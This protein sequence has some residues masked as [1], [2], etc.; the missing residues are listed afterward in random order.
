MRG[1]CS[2]A[3]GQGKRA[4]EEVGVSESD[5]SGVVNIS[6]LTRKVMLLSRSRTTMSAVPVSATPQDGTASA[7]AAY[8]IPSKKAFLQPSSRT[9]RRDPASTT[10]VDLMTQRSKK[11]TAATATAPASR[12][13]TSGLRVRGDSFKSSRDVARGASG[14]SG[15]STAARALMVH[16]GAAGAGPRPAERKAPMLCGGGSAV[17][18]AAPERVCHLDKKRKLDEMTCVD[19]DEIHAVMRVKSAKQALECAAPLSNR[20]LKVSDCWKS[21]CFVSMC[22]VFMLEVCLR[23]CAWGGENAC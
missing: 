9:G 3:S 12:S 15:S 10:F 13:S 17:V 23:G 5:G 18:V 14:S 22:C 16:G 19:S 6:R 21:F 8:E 2:T 20:H 11:G 4:F 1:R 7:S